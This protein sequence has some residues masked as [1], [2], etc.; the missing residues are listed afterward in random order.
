MKSSQA[1]HAKMSSRN[2]A[3]PGAAAAP[4]HARRFG[5]ATESPVDRER[6]ILAREEWLRHREHVIAVHDA[7]LRARETWVQPAA[8]VEQLMN[9]MREANQRLIL[10][11]VQA[12]SLS[13]EA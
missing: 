1:G 11:A 10:A 8:D 7:A 2:A 4:R 9:R 12:Q 3:T 5:A 13:D 6:D